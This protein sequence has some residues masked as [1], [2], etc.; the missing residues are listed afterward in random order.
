MNMLV[1][2]AAVATINLAAAAS[3]P[4][5]AAAKDLVIGSGHNLG[6]MKPSATQGDCCALCQHTEGCKAWTWHTPSAKKWAFK[7]ALHSSV[8][9]VQG[10][11][12]AVSGVPTAHMPPG[13]LPP[14]PPPPPPA[15]NYPSAE[16]ACAAFDT[17]TLIMLMHG[18]GKEHCCLS[19]FSKASI[20]PKMKKKREVPCQAAFTNTT[21]M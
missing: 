15:H 17:T 14:P 12:G 6:S 5:C 18:F 1:I 2:F 20:I 8:Q 19:C 9:G 13:I 10:E 11:H 4:V 16:A 21:L 7:C 3:A